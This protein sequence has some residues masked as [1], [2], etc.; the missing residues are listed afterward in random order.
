MEKRWKIILG[1]L[2]IVILFIVITSYKLIV[3]D[4]NAYV[5]KICVNNNLS[6]VSGISCIQTDCLVKCCSD[7]SESSC[8]E[9]QV[10]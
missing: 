3:S 4:R 9:F 8:S 2:A 7:K 10:Y 5:E 6:Y 1:I